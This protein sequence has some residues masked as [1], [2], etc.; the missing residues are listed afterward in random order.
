MKLISRY[1]NYILEGKKV[2]LFFKNTNQDIENILNQSKPDF[3]QFIYGDT[4]PLLANQISVHYNVPIIW[5]YGVSR[6]L[7]EDDLNFG[8]YAFPILDKHSELGGGTGISFPWNWIT[9]I[10]RRY[11][12]A[13]GLNP[14][15]VQEAIQKL[16][17]WGLDVASGVES[18]PGQKES[19]LIREFVKNVR[20]K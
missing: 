16:N 13:G 3:I 20:F 10:K 17:P 4:S 1:P 11:L 18:R 8:E 7:N 14:N 15:N 19:F 6:E 2:Y 12:L 5:Q 9:N